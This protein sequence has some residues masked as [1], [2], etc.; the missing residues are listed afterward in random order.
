MNLNHLNIVTHDLEASQTF[1]ETFFDFEKLFE[2]GKEV[3]L[4][5]ER[6]DL[7]AIALVD[8]EV[9]SPKWLHFG[10]CVDSPQQVRKM[11]EK[12][13]SSGVEFFE[14][15]LET[16]SFT[17]FYS[18]DPAGHRVEVSCFKTPGA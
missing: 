12:M 17:A 18:R 16:D 2:A 10:F 8:S 14:S 5:N 9:D 11:Y 3:F 15:F 6:G 1:Y 7:L 4:K 13:Q